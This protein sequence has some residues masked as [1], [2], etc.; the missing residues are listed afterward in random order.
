MEHIRQAF[1]R[2][3][4]DYDSQREYVIPD[5]QRYY[6]AAVWAMETPS[7]PNRQSLMSGPAP[8]C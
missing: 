2:F 6:G 8:A 1:N 3:A 5:L 4:Q 7:R